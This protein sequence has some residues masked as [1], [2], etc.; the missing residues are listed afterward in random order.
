MLEKPDIM[1]V[2]QSEGIELRQRGRDFW[3]LCPFHEEKSPSFKV[4]PERQS[5]YCFGCNEGGDAVDFIQ[6][7]RGIGFKDALQVLGIRA[8]ERPK[9]DPKAERQKQLREAYGRWKRFYYWHL[10]DRSISLHSISIAAKNRK[11]PLSE[12]LGFM[13]A[14]VVSQIPQIEARLD[15]LQGRDESAIFQLFKESSHV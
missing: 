15:I 9:P 10:C 14:E 6:K 4:S 1:N 2:L 13:V 11:T 3:G 5:F 8:G 7:L 12:G